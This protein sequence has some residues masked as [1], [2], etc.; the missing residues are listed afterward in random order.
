MTASAV[1]SCIT[2]GAAPMSGAGRGHWHRFLVSFAG[3]T[4]CVLVLQEATKAVAAAPTTA[5]VQEVATKA[6]APAAAADDDDDDDDDDEDI[7]LFGEMTP[8]RFYASYPTAP[9]L[10]VNQSLMHAASPCMSVRE[11]SCGQSAVRRGL[12]GGGR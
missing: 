5:A 11:G 12:E 8:V 10:A 9:A 3:L 7:D 2:V 4:K 1:G 6:P